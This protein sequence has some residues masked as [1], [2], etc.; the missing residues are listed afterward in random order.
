MYLFLASKE[1]QV[2]H[3]HEV[4]ITVMSQKIKNRDFLRLAP[5]RLE[6]L[7][8]LSSNDFGVIRSYSRSTT[9]VI[10][11]FRNCWN[12]NIH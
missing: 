8:L 3:L 12:S 7:F 2:D 6:N 11:Y 1:V 10:D 5:S 9:N 4:V